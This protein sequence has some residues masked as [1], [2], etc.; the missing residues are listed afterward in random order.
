MGK[1]S[2]AKDTGRWKNSVKAGLAASGFITA[3]IVVIAVCFVFGIDMATVGIVLAIAILVLAGIPLAI[4][5]IRGTVRENADIRD[6]NATC[7][8][9]M[10]RYWSGRNTKRL[11]SDYEEWTKG[12]HSSYSRVHFAGEVIG[13]LQDAKQYEEALRLLDDLEK[14]DMKPRERYDYETY[15]DQAR[16]QLLEGIEKEKKRAEERAR[17]KNLK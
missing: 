14:I 4:F 17:N 10:K 6:E 2:E 12:E 1:E 16:P 9:I 7:Q 8:P 13:E 5:A 3:I 15:R 11:V